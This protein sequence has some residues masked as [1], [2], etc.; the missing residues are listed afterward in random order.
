M[1]WWRRGVRG[2]KHQGFFRLAAH[3]DKY[4]AGTTLLRNT[5]LR[6]HNQVNMVG[7]GIQERNTVVTP[8]GSNQ[9][10]SADQQRGL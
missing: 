2:V 9:G 3:K 6:R 4:R 7:A 5:K 10:R 8:N 1:S